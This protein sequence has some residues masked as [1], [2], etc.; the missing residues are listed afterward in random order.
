MAIRE[1]IKT[2]DS[3]LGGFGKK[4]V[5]RR[6]LNNLKAKEE[7]WWDGEMNTFEAYKNK[8]SKEYEN[9]KFLFSDKKAIVD[10]VEQNGYYI[11]PRAFNKEL[12]LDIKTK[13]NNYILNNKCLNNP[14]RDS[15]RLHGELNGPA[16]FFSNDEMKKGEQYYRENTNYIQI[17]EPI[18]NC[19][20][21]LNI[22]LS[23]Q[24]IDIAYHYLGAMPAL[25]GV[26][27]R[28]SYANTLS[29]FDTL[30]FHSD[31]NS[32]KFLK[33]FFYLNDVD[34]DGGPFCFVRGSH[35]KKFIGWTQKYRWTE[36][37]MLEYYNTE[38]ITD[39]TA[40]VGDMIIANT[41]GF[42]RGKKVVNTDRN[43]LTIYYTVHPDINSKDSKPSKI[44]K[45]ALKGLSAKQIAACD[46][47]EKI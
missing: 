14:I 5:E 37:E 46:F 35:R 16:V 1:I 40:N 34:K 11:V 20:E 18:L 33:F 30:Y 10:G 2:V 26:D 31:P 36:E 38:D 45:D 28:K 43:M 19:K 7:K 9:S 29:E 39:I 13:L 24:L 47:L 25:Y 27:L 15:I 6:R 32:A 22:A 17:S 44:F 4:I 12:L 8:R 23:E 21:I 3:A 41:R 42:H